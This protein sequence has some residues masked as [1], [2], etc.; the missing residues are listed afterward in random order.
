MADITTAFTIDENGLA[1]FVDESTLSSVV[2]ATADPTITGVSTALGSLY[3]RTNGKLYIKTGALDTDWTQTV[4]FTDLTAD[5][6]GVLKLSPSTYD[7]VQDFIGLF[8]SRGSFS[9]GV[10][11]SNGDGTVAVTGGTGLIHDA[12]ST[13]SPLYFFDW[14]TNASVS[15]TDVMVNYIYVD[16]NGG[17]PQ[18][19]T[20]TSQTY[21]N[22]FILLGVVYRSGTQVSVNNITRLKIDNSIA[23]VIERFE[24]TQ[25]FQHASGARISETGTRNIAIT[26]GAFWEGIDQYVFAAFDTSGV[27]TFTYWYRSAPSTWVSVPA[28]TQIDIT[29]FNDPTSGLVAL[30]AN[31]YNNHWVYVGA[32]GT[33]NVVYGLEN[34]NS[35][36]TAQEALIP[37]LPPDVVKFAVL[38]GRIIIRRNQVTFVQVDSAFELSFQGASISNHNDL[39]GLQG[40]TANEYYHFTSAEYTSWQDLNGTGNGLTVHSGSGTWESRT[41]TGTTNRIS[42]SNGDGIAANPTIDIDAA[43]VGQTSITT[44]GTITTGTWD[45]TTIATTRGGTGLTSYATGD[46]LYASAINTLS[47]LTIGASATYLRSNGTIPAWSTIPGTEVTG[48]ALTKV[49]DTNVTL[50]LGGTPTTALLRAASLTLGWSG[51][52]A[53]SRGGTGVS[54]FGGTNTLLY[55]TATD[56]LSSVATANT[57]ALV[58]SSTGVPSWTSGTVANRVLRTDGT[59]I[60]FSQVALTT[61]V[62]GRLPFANL[63]QGSARSVLGVTGNATADVASIQGTANQVL[64]VNGAGT[65]LTFGSIDLSQSAAVG[66]SILG[67]ANGGTNGTT[68]TTGFNNLSPLTT[69]GD[70]IVHNGTN[71]IR[72]AVG[73]N[74]FVLTADSTVGSGIK[75]AAIAGTVL[76]LYNENPVTP[77]ASTVAGNNSV[78]IGQGQTA[79]GQDS[80]VLGG[81]SNTASATYSSAHGN[82]AIAR[83]Y[84]GSVQSSG[85]FAIDGDAQAGRYTLRT[86]TTNATSTTMFLDGT[87]GTQRLVLENTSA[88][89]FDILLV[90]RNTAAAQAAG[91]RFV[92]V[93]RRTATAASTAIVASSKTVIAEDNAAWDANITADTTNGALNIAVTGVAATTID[94]VAIVSTAEVDV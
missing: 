53:V 31:R 62:S 5:N 37:P 10:I 8:G 25:P 33:V 80:I 88:W 46:T 44:L 72:Q 27:D 79:S 56:T 49:D 20:Q 16:Y 90:A 36:S 19:V 1:L 48:A 39:S 26:S 61:D 29:Q 93:I 40:G 54:T 74:N 66:T 4:S 14:A 69:K 17:S 65:A 60:T 59:T 63:T 45:A 30:S 85:R 81:S 71:N 91:Y 34:T 24:A 76:Q 42:L 89:T 51:Q 75:W 18:V 11:T 47:V 83:H 28:Q 6:I 87:G 21:D 3:L 68:N 13:L 15:L 55:T 32:E 92:G 73:T 22:R 57:S 52:L 38:V 82:R 23:G 35:L 78:A 58:T 2:A 86:Q 70:L 43:Y 94:W 64:V 77:T 7:T 67:I 12:N 84:G 41:I 9:G 50:T